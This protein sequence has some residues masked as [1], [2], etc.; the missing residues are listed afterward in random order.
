MA[1]DSTYLTTAPS[2][3]DDASA[4]S[5]GNNIVNSICYQSLTSHQI[6]YNNTSITEVDKRQH[7]YIAPSPGTITI[8]GSPLFEDI[9]YLSNL[10]S[11][12][13]LTK[14]ATTTDPCTRASC[15]VTS[16][17]NEKLSLQNIN[18]LIF[19]DAQIGI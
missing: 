18:Y 15:Y 19:P 17:T 9:V 5:G 10:R 2:L 14:T 7:F 3:C 13:T 12:Y 16:G 4:T 8:V 6:I 1:N 11:N